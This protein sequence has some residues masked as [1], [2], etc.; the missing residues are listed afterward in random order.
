VV[1]ALI[2]SNTDEYVE[3]LISNRRISSLAILILLLGLTN[4]LAFALLPGLAMTFS[5]QW[6]SLN[7]RVG[8]FNL[9]L[10]GLILLTFAVQ[11]FSVI[12]TKKEIGR[13]STATY[14]LWEGAGF[15]W[16]FIVF[17]P[18]AVMGIVL[19]L[20]LRNHRQITN[21]RTILLLC[22][23]SASI[24]LATY[25]MAGIADRYLLAPFVLSF[26]ALIVL[27]SEI[28]VK[29]RKLDL[30]IMVMPLAVAFFAS[31]LW[32]SA[33]SYLTSGLNW[34]NQVVSSV[35]TCSTDQKG[36]VRLVFSDGIP[37]EVPC[38]YIL[39]D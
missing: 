32:F 17:S 19:Y 10:I 9:L 31:I 15:Y 37:N 34:S 6:R 20:L 29:Q 12:W 28:G 5:W 30:L 24:Y 8:G 11:L 33:N 3:V 22:V 18:I 36:S 2:I 7:T 16:K 4:P 25:V 14:F 27:V 1:V 23:Q 38:D 39:G 35:K 13:K 26:A 21:S